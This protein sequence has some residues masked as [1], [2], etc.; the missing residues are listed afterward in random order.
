MRLIKIGRSNENDIVLE[1][2]SKVSRFHAELFHDNDGKTFITDLSSANGTFVNG[3][4][5]KGTH[6]LKNLD[7]IVIGKSDPIPWKDQFKEEVSKNKLKERKMSKEKIKN[8]EE[9]P[10]KIASKGWIIAGFIFSL[11]GGYFGAAMGANYAFGKYDKKTKTL[12]YIMILLSAIMIG[13][14]RLKRTVN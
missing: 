8:V 1:N 11:L 12:G 10:K 3:K 5:I 6:L 2:D 9:V 13:L 7:V 14:W 4:K